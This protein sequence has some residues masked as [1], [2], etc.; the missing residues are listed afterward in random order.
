VT[1]LLVLIAVAALVIAKTAFDRALE[2]DPEL[3]EKLVSFARRNISNPADA[4]DVV[5]LAFRR[6]WEREAAGQAWSPEA[7]GPFEKYMYGFVRGALSNHRRRRRNAPV[8]PLEDPELAK[9]DLPHPEQALEEREQVTDRQNFLAQVR[10]VV[11]QTKHGPLAVAVM[12]AIDKG[13]TD[14]SEIAKKLGCELEDVRKAR[15]AIGDHAKALLA[16]L[17]AEEA[18]E[19]S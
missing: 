6:A 7:D 9:S 3:P 11:A 1:G 18:E 13:M 8:V 5:G 16:R 10:A 4:E 2:A 15:R 17:R 19:A 14:Y 12:D